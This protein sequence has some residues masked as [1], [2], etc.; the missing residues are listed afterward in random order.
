MNSMKIFMQMFDKFTIW[1]KPPKRSTEPQKPTANSFEQY[2]E[3]KY[4]INPELF[5][6]RPD[7][8]PVFS[9]RFVSA[10]KGYRFYRL[11]CET[12]YPSEHEQNNKMYLE[13]FKVNKSLKTVIILHGWA[14]KKKER[15][16]A[17]CKKLAGAG[18]S[19]VLVTLPYH[20]ERAPAGTWSGEYFLS[21]NVNR[22]IEAVK[23]TVM[24]IR[25]IINFLNK[26]DSIVGICG[27]SLGG[28]L[29]HIAMS[30]EGRFDFGISALAGGNPAGVVLDGLMTRYIRRD[31][32]LAG[33]SPQELGEIWQII[34]PGIL[35]CKMAKDKLLMINGKYDQIIPAVYTR[36]LWEHL[37]RPEIR[38]YPCAHYSM[39]FFINRVFNDI[40][41]YA[42][43]V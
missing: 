33:V 15:E 2:T 16:R 13:Y 35:P 41:I 22:T 10:T 39:Y 17:L 31:I 38:W 18:I 24:E 29:A 11:E 36:Q 42:D 4:L 40:C 26:Q 12:C 19:S 7:G 14:I 28:I 9:N 1:W 43:N 32:E 20:M 21:G 27:L 37:G 3:E 6:E 25:Y 5:Y 8:A 23:Q 34:N 30:A